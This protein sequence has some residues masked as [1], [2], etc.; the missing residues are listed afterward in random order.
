ML[1]SGNLIILGAA[2]AWAIYA[3]LQKLLTSRGHSPQDL[4]LVF[5]LLPALSLWPWT[6]FRLL[7][8]LSPGMWLLMAFLGANTLFAYGFLGEALKRLPAWQVSLII[9]LNPLITLT[10]MAA[11]GTLELDWVPADHV[12]TLGY[13]AALMVV[14]GVIWVLLKAT[15]ATER[16]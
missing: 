2:L 10:A 1:W 4:N 5:Y 7:A 9:T 11:L 13:G 8:E 3:A 16:K 12:G 6:D 15:P 14:S